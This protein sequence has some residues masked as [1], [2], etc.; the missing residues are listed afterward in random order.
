MGRLLAAAV[1][2]AVTV[3]CPLAASVPLLEDTFSHADVLMI[4]QFS[5]EVPVFVSAK[6]RDDAKNGPPWAPTAAKPEFGATTKISGRLARAFMRFCP[7]GVPQPVQ[8]S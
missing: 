2:L 4:D 3:D 6:I 1:R 8:R 5:D 7:L